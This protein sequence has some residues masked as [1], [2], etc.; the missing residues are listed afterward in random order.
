MQPWLE[1]CSARCFF[2]KT[3]KKQRADLSGKL[4]SF[5]KNVAQFPH[6]N[7]LSG[8]ESN[9]FIP[10]KYGKKPGIPF[11]LICLFVDFWTLAFG[12]KCLLRPD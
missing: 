3:I 10:K 5:E 11:Q 8:S 6:K 9:F 12:I 4:N 1:Y 7:N 2:S